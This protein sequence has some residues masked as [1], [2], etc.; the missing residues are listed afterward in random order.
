MYN[1]QCMNVEGE[2]IDLH[3]ATGGYDRLDDALAAVTGALQD[4]SDNEDVICVS[5][6]RQRPAPVEAAAA[7][8]EPAKE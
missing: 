7:A 8:S 4:T 6:G 5:I 3:P 2:V 1:V